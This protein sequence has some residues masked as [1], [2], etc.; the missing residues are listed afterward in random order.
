V[1]FI[2]FMKQAWDLWIL[3]VSLRVDE[4]DHFKTHSVWCILLT[5]STTTHS[6]FFPVC[7]CLTATVN[8]SLNGDESKEKCRNACQWNLW[9]VDVTHLSSMNNRIQNEQM[10]WSRRKMVLSSC[11]L[12]IY[13]LANHVKHNGTHFFTISF[14]LVHF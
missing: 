6:S 9:E 14:A 8:V 11:L 5:A 2:S 7:R 1:I 13:T 3:E 4:S 10:F 12:F